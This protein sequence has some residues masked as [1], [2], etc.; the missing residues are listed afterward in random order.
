MQKPIDV[1]VEH[2]VTT[3]GLVTVH[4][5]F[6]SV[7]LQ[8]SGYRKSDLQAKIRPAVELQSYVFTG[9]IEVE[10]VCYYS[11]D[12]FYEHGHRPD[13]DNVVKPI[14]DSLKGTGGILIDD[15]QVERIESRAEFDEVTNGD[16]FSV[17]VNYQNS[18]WVS[19]THEFIAVDDVWCKPSLA[20]AYSYE[21]GKQMLKNGN[22][23]GRGFVQIDRLW[24]IKQVEAAG[25]TVKPV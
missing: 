10:V 25:F 9:A 8:A 24:R 22:P 5:P 17:K 2:D 3:P 21:L 4:C 13:I 23:Q 7:S 6:P 11:V 16:W 15:T 20:R 1:V 19:R 12:Y 18:D 14:L